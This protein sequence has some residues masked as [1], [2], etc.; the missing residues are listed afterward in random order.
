[1]RVLREYLKN[2]RPQECEKSD[3]SVPTTFA[4]LP[5]YPCRIPRRPGDAIRAV[6]IETG[7]VHRV[8]FPGI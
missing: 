5:S 2:H 8:P 6:H 3:D 7:H 4:H 1:M